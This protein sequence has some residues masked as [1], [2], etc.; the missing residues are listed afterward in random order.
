MNLFTNVRGCVQNYWLSL[1]L[2][3]FTISPLQAQEGYL[4]LQT[5]D[6]PLQNVSNNTYSI[7][8][9][10]LG[11]IYFAN[12]SGILRFDGSFWKLIETPSVPRKI[13][14]HNPTKK[15]FVVCDNNFGYL[16]TKKQG[17]YQIIFMDSLKSFESQ[18]L[19]YNDEKIIVKTTHNLFIV[20][21]ETNNFITHAQIDS[22]YEHIFALENKLFIQ[23]RTQEIFTLQELLGKETAS[24]ISTKKIT[25]SSPF[26]E[27]A[28][29]TADKT[30]KLY[31]FENEKFRPFHYSVEDY[32]E[33][34]F[35]T[36][37][38]DVNAEKFAITTL[39]GGCVII[40][41][42][43]GVK[44]EII[45]F[46]S[47]LND[48]EV[49]CVFSDSRGD[50]WISTR[51]GIAKASLNLPV[52][53]YS[54]YPGL[55]GTI[56]AGLSLNNQLY[57]ATNDGVFMLVPVQEY[58]E[59]EHLV[60]SEK[61]ESSE[62]QVFQVTKTIKKN[63]KIRFN[64]IN[65]VN[66]EN[67][68]VV[69]N[70][71][72]QID[73][74]V[75]S[76]A[77]SVTQVFT[78]E[79]V[80]RE[81][82]VQ[83]TGFV[84]KQVDNVS[85][86]CLQ[87]LEVED[88]I[89]AVTNIGLFALDSL[90][91]DFLLPVLNLTMAYPDPLNPDILFLAA[92][93]NLYSVSISEGTVIDT[94]M[95]DNEILSFERVGDVLYT[96]SKTH[97][98]LVGLNE[99][100]G[101]TGIIKNVSTGGNLTGSTQVRKINE[102]LLFRSSQNILYFDHEKAVEISRKPD[103][104]QDMVINQPG[105]TWIR[106]NH[107]WFYNSLKENAGSNAVY[108]NLFNRIEQI[109]LD[110][111]EQIWVVSDKGLYV[112]QNTP[113]YEKSSFLAL[114]SQVE[115]QN[116]EKSIYP[117]E[118]IPFSEN[119][120]RIRFS[121]PYYLNETST[122]YQYKIQGLKEEWSSWSQK[123][124]IEI[125]YVPAGR[126]SIVLRA[127]NALNQISQEDTFSFSIRKPFWQNWAFY[128]LVLLLT[129]LILY[130]LARLNLR[131][132]KKHQQILQQEVQRATHKI[133]KQRDEIEYIN[134]ELLASIEYGQYIQEAM[135]PNQ[136]EIFNFTKDAFIFLRARD[137]VSGD[138]HWF[139]TI[140][141]KHI[142][143]AADCTGH[144][145]PGAFMSMIGCSLLNQIIKEEHILDP[146]EILQQLNDRIVSALKQKE[147]DKLQYDG[148]DISVTVYDPENRKLDFAGG[149]SRMIYFEDGKMN[150][151]DG[152]L[153]G[154]GGIYSMAK[155]KSYNT[156]T[157]NHR[158]PLDCYLFSDGFP[159]QNGGPRDKKYSNKRFREFLESIHHLP[160]HV[161]KHQLAIELADW[162]KKEDQRDDI[163][164]IGFRIP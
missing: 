88:N 148:M 55:S 110:A 141:G 42:H 137:I 154:I 117:D 89:I 24:G 1:I 49:L 59:V 159:D 17:Q 147:R 14:Y 37:L 57:V 77:T 43:S 124:T 16:D 106:K 85:A 108:L 58:H 73:V 102:Q 91:S 100:A 142:I 66:Q 140:D 3:A 19:L 82:A 12:E 86:N 128:L 22:P 18:E 70:I 25:A 105:H 143:I 146:G 115:T 135:L 39:T 150:I 92:D 53:V 44:E 93:N 23:T 132:L 120:I 83:T 46:Q 56:N 50:I 29:I 130:I 75:D 161:Q 153:F 145:V 155:K 8:E 54:K 69:R 6:I 116:S 111:R 94:L 126:Y 5:Y 2:A 157:I 33:G 144:G 34:N 11:I 149:H 27:S 152:D 138:F 64:A 114:I 96:G 160:Y 119:A 31:I 151:M 48:N 71:P 131:R 13:L 28:L 80:K 21:P 78:N 26:S 98:F 72:V 40:N 81:Y 134:S 133:S 163:L 68:P 87:L 164:V 139:A 62:V 20:D 90:D 107:E 45:N 101:F 15:L 162:K 127:K 156:Y 38:F 84:F 10:D 125:P 7:A 61:S 51:D 109:F 9:T 76:V 122:L 60:Q 63:I 123:N 4:Y 112:I 67:I 95:L 121:A 35:I 129:V 47:G 74:P 136:D 97:V 41:K 30:G 103:F 65:P 32:V 118:V 99:K 79:T 52:R 104:I 36:G 158:S 113:D